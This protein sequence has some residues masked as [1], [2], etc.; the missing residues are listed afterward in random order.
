MTPGKHG[1]LI[2]KT[3]S[4][5]H[6]V[7]VFSTFLWL[8]WSPNQPVR[9]VAYLLATCSA[10]LIFRSKLAER[11]LVHRH[12]WAIGLL[13][14]FDVVVLVAVLAM[15]LDRLPQLI[16]AALVWISVRALLIPRTLEQD[17]SS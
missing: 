15:T 7:L 2:D 5:L 6:D 3:V 9:W 12:P 14:F 11:T 8:C 13:M 1:R 16:V 17:G 10:L 4:L